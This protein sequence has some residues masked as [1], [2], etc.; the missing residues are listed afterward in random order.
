MARPFTAKAPPF[1]YYMR[2]YGFGTFFSWFY[3]FLP[4]TLL[5]AKGKRNCRLCGR[6]N[7]YK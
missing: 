2:F 1:I 7:G 6:K 5:E 4:E 3:C